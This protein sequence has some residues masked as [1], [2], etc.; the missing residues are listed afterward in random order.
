MKNILL[1]IA[2]VWTS[3]LFFSCGNS[4]EGIMKR[5]K[6]PETKKEHVSDNYFGTIVEDPYRWL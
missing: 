6:Y 2:I 3:F 5:L 4:E 1:L